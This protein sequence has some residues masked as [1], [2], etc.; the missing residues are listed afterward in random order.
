MSFLKKAI[1]K[2]FQ[3]FSFF[4]QYLKSRTFL[5]IGVSLLVGIFDGF[6]L[7]M[8]F[9][10]LQMTGD[11]SDFDNSQLGN[12]SFLVEG[13]QSVGI[14]LTTYSVLIIILIFFSLKG[15]FKYLAGYYRAVYQQF[16]VAKLRI[17][18]ADALSNFSYYS[19]VSSDSGRI[20]NTFTSEVERVNGAFRAYFMAIQSAVLVLVYIGMAFFVNA[21]FALLVSLGG[22]LS[23]IL[24]KGLYKATKKASRAYT[25]ES[26]SFQGLLLQ[27]VSNFKYLK[28]TSLIFKYSSKLKHR[29]REIELLQRRMGILKARM[30]ALREPITMLVVVAVIII[31]MEFFGEGIVT[32]SVSLLLFYRAM[33]ALLAAQNEWNSFL[34]SEGSLQN[35]KSFS[36]ELKAG[37]DHYGDK[38]FERFQSKIE[39]ENL[40]FNYGETSILKN[41]DLTI[42]RNETVAVIGESGSGKTTLVNLIAGLIK[43]DSGR[44]LFD[45]VSASELDVRTL[46]KRIGYITQ[47]PVIFSDTIFNNVSFWEEK[48]EENLM[49]FR[50]ALKKASI[51]AFVDELTDKEET[52]LGQNG[53]NLSGGQKQRLSIARE[54]YK[55]VDFL[56]MDE[57]TSAL[58]SETEKAI[59]QNIDDLRGKY[60]IIIIAHRLST[61]KNVDKIILLK[62]GEIERAGSFDALMAQSEDFKK[63]VMLQEFS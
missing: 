50:E 32:I 25:S 41:V 6:G 45:G 55:D 30:Q 60:T 2:Y 12:M 43:P 48:T 44:V 28:A 11:N 49:R 20:Q 27:N 38:P 51:D 52:M 1:K 26:H 15:F 61:I 13:F 21:E 57:A 4:Y 31:Q 54:L 59:Q 3:S 39:V 56:M 40:C 46:Q 62:R 35:M 47:E 33:T 34:G 58:D 24:F 22:L 53:I 36:K 17:S 63:M 18:N 7:T 37:E 23:N 8:F 5:I 42:N 29:I 10:L 16:F 9:P 19:F 14:S